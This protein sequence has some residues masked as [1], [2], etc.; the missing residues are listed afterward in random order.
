[1]EGG[2]GV[3]G[4]VGGRITLTDTTGVK[5]EE[6]TI[7][8]GV[9]TSLVTDSSRPV[10]RDPTEGQRVIRRGEVLTARGTGWGWW[11]GGGG[12]GV[13]NGQR[14][15]TCVLSGSFRRGEPRPPPECSDTYVTEILSAVC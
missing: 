7:T 14:F 3:G 2:G 4:G 5:L 6:R 12:G 11:G 10:I 1:M 13:W 8:P 15:H 9:N